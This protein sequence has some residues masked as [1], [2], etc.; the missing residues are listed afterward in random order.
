MLE[1]EINHLFQMAK[2]KSLVLDQDL[3]LLWSARLVVL[4]AGLLSMKVRLD[5]TFI[6]TPKM[7]NTEPISKSM[8]NSSDSLIPKLLW[9][10]NLKWLKMARL[11]CSKMIL[12]SSPTPLSPD[13]SLFI[14]FNYLL[15]P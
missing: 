3:G 7:K 6:N 4:P 12:T 10:A 2:S 5:L 14:D 13:Y 15:N 1:K 8:E 9:L 11:K